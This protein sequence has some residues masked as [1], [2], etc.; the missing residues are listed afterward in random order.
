[1][2]EKDGRIARCIFNDKARRNYLSD[3][4]WLTFKVKDGVVYFKP[5]SRSGNNA[6][7][8][9][10][11]PDGRST[12][13]L[14]NRL[15]GGH[16]ADILRVTNA[17]YMLLHEA[18]RG[19]IRLEYIQGSRPKVPCCRVYPL[20]ATTLQIIDP[21]EHVTSAHRVV[22]EAFAK[23]HEYEMENRLARRRKPRDIREAA[24]ILSTFQFTI[25]EMAA[26]K[27]ERQDSSLQ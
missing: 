27:R 25:S 2:P 13:D 26:L 11:L 12:I 16:L 15:L 19:W 21:L 6:I 4:N 7:E 3:A 24:R 14:T 10:A 22:L 18:E 17:S 9:E 8:L 20:N 1:M 5:S 23:V